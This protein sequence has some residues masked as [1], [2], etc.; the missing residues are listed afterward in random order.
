MT[1]DAVLILQTLF[2]T[3]WRLFTSWY[4]PGTNVT[5]A[6]WAFFALTVVLLIRVIRVLL[7]IDS[8]DRGK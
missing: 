5:P 1:A 7:G 8:G 2:G 3:I 4:I 6:S